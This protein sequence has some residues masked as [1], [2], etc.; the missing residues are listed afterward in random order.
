MINIIR[1]FHLITLSIV[2]TALYWF[3][4][5]IWFNN[6]LANDD[7]K[8]PLLFVAGIMSVFASTFIEIELA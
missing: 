5:F 2:G 7:A 6:A 3:Y 8:V 4:D 1:L